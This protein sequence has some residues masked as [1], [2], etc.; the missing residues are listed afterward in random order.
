[1]AMLRG[2]WVAPSVYA[3][4]LDP[5]LLDLSL[6]HIFRGD[7]HHRDHAGAEAGGDEIGRRKR[8]APAVVVDRGVGG[9]ARLAGAVRRTAAQLALVIDVD[10]DHEGEAYGRLNRASP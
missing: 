4:P 8:L 7:P 2:G 1:M 10:V 9:E 6:I 5:S 3:T